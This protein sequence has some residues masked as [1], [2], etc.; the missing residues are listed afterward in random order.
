MHTG[1]PSLCSP[2]FWS[3]CVPCQ[4]LSSCVHTCCSASW[5]AFWALKALS[6]ETQKT[7]ST[8]SHCY[9]K[10]K[11]LLS[12]CSKKNWQINMNWSLPTEELVCWFFFNS[13][14]LIL[15]P[16]W[17]RPCF[18]QSCNGHVELDEVSFSRAP[19]QMSVLDRSISTLLGVTEQQ[20]TLSR[21]NHWPQQTILLR[22]MWASVAGS[23]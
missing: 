4:R 5:L 13:G 15:A 11:G 7:I 2:V 1:G 16:T 3:L 10:Y 22:R 8:E 18:P 19:P 9:L 20:F 17:I 14:S 21:L 12:V 6:T 23:D